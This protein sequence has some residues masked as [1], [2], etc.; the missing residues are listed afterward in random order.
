MVDVPP[1][2]ATTVRNLA[3]QRVLQGTPL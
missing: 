2:V 1:A 3:E